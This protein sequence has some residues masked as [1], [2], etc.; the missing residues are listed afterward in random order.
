MRFLKHAS[1]GRL[2]APDGRQTTFTPCHRRLVGK[3]GRQTPGDWPPHGEPLICG[4]LIMH[5]QAVWRLQ[6]VARRLDT[7]PQ[8]SCREAWQANLRDVALPT[9]NPFHALTYFTVCVNVSLKCFYYWQ[10]H[11]LA[12][13]RTSSFNESLTVGPHCPLCLSLLCLCV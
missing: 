4:F 7:I 5:L 1:S 13:A 11:I 8:T 10:R 6:T 2:E 3:L 9:A 12:P